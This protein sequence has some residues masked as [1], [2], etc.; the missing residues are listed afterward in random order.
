MHHRLTS[1]S[2]LAHRH[3]HKII[4]NNPCYIRQAAQGGQKYKLAR[5]A[6]GNP[7]TCQDAMKN[8]EYQDEIVA[9]GYCGAQDKNGKALMRCGRCKGASYC[10]ADCQK[11]DWALHK[12][13]C[14]T[15]RESKKGGEDSKNG[16]GPYF[17]GHDRGVN[18]VY[19]KSS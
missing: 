18:M 3:K 13:A 1:T 7:F 17:V 10:G 19:P 2:E 9:C 11:A 14:K 16:Q 15:A 6:G 4:C 5:E 8:G 12:K